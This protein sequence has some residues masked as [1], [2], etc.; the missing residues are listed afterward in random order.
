VPPFR[1]LERD[2]EGLRMI[3]EQLADFEAKIPNKWKKSGY[4]FDQEVKRLRYDFSAGIII[5]TIPRR[6]G[7]YAR[8]VELSADVKL[9][10]RMANVALRALQWRSADEPW[11]H[12]KEWTHLIARKNDKTY[13]EAARRL[14]VPWYYDRLVWIDQHVPIVANYAI[15]TGRREEG[16]EMCSRLQAERNLMVEVWEK[17]APREWH[18]PDDITEVTA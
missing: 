10:R 9:G 7:L 2:Y 17:T 6:L 12:K 13:A 11:M 4:L 14:W 1:A 8:R 5:T 18:E 16:N 3:L 15:K